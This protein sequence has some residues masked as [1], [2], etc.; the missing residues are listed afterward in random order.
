MS[1]RPKTYCRALLTVA[2]GL[3][4][5]RLLSQPSTE[6]IFYINEVDL[7]A[8]PPSSSANPEVGTIG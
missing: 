8:A 1:A 3:V 4:G 6:G 5:P 7:G 2:A